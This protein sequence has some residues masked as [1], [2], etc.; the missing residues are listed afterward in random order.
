MPLPGLLRDVMGVTLVGD[1]PLYSEKQGVKFAGM[2][3][4]PG[5]ACQLW[6]DVLKPESAEVLA[7]YTMGDYAGQAAIAANQFGKGRAIYLGARLEPAALGRVLNTVAASAGL[8]SE[9]DAPAGVEVAT[10]RSG[11]HA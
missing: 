10:R 6:A 2:L 5:A 7:I 1:A 8:A 4:G 9:I 3:A 11:G